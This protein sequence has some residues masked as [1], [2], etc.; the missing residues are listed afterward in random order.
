MNYRQ[1]L[2][3]YEER[4]WRMDLEEIHRNKD[5]VAYTVPCP[6]RRDEPDNWA[7]TAVPMLGDA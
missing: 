7:V 5:R 2:K 6:R 3:D 1:R 4:G